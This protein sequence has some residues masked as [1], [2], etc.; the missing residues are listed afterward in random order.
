MYLTLLEKT[1][2]K[3]KD[4]LTFLTVVLFILILGILNLIL[5]PAFEVIV[6]TAFILVTA[7][8]ILFMFYKVNNKLKMLKK[9]TNILSVY[10]INGKNKIYRNELISISAYSILKKEAFT[11]QEFEKIIQN[12]DFYINFFKKPILV[13]I[14]KD[15]DSPV[16]LLEGTIIEGEAKDISFLFNEINPDSKINNELFFLKRK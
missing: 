6:I 10:Q 1:E 12:K 16:R 5:K 11:Y 14:K 13:F 7:F 2:I 4:Y 15:N 8:V 9:I 3:K